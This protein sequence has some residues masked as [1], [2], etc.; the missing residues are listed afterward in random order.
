MGVRTFA[1]I[2]VAL[3]VSSAATDDAEMSRRIRLKSSKQLRA[4]L[5]GVG[6]E[7]RSDL[8]LEELRE[9]ALQHD[10][11]DRA[12]PPSRGAGGASAE[13]ISKLGDVLLSLLDGNGD[14]LLTRAE[15]VEGWGRARES[16]VGAMSST[17][18]AAFFKSMDSDSSEDV[19]REELA[20]GLKLVADT[21]AASKGARASDAPSAKKSTPPGGEKTRSG[22]ASRGGE[23]KA[24]PGKEGK[25]GEM[26]EK[27]FKL[28]DKDDDGT[29]SATET[30]ELTNMAA[31]AGM[32]AM[33][34]GLD[35]DNFFT[36]MDADRNGRVTRSEATAMFRMLGSAMG[37]GPRGA[38]L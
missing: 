30:R 16:G 21:L 20:R 12:A 28:L 22:K 23:K 17:D 37:A 24:T 32:G 11:L 4:L 8:S 19:T 18:P 14:G 1:A 7:A 35:A 34:G 29:L 10:A 15:V 33:P 31:S 13:D 27:L 9:L 5:D 38:Q 36:G 26:G 6:V 3:L 25:M 2:F